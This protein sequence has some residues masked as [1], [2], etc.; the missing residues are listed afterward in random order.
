MNQP[1][2]ERPGR[3]GTYLRQNL[4][5]VIF[6]ITSFILLGLL[7]YKSSRLDDSLARLDQMQREVGRLQDQKMQLTEN[8]A[9]AE[10]KMLQYQQQN[11]LRKGLPPFSKP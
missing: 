4:F 6:L 11:Q 3:L 1:H 7:L 2:T 8:L 5:A 10:E 9:E